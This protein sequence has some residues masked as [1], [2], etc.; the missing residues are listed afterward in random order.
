MGMEC[1]AAFED[2][3]VTSP[4]RIGTPTHRPLICCWLAQ[5][6][7]MGTISAELSQM[8]SRAKEQQVR[9]FFL[10]TEDHLALCATPHHLHRAPRTCRARPRATRAM[11]VV[12]AAQAM[13]LMLALLDVHFHAATRVAR[14]R[15]CRRVS[16]PQSTLVTWWISRMSS[17]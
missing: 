11:L 10:A 3:T 6:A 17:R 15:P 5:R 2:G 12:R 8:L 16:P 7:S 14:A 4:T 13:L 1:V 9:T